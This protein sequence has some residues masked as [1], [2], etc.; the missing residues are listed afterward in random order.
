MDNI[1]RISWSYRNFIYSR[2]FWTQ[3]H[4]RTWSK[5]GFFRYWTYSCFLMLNSTISSIYN[6]VIFTICICYALCR[7]QSENI[8]PFRCSSLYF[9][10]VSSSICL[11]TRSLPH[12]YAC[13][14]SWRMQVRFK[15]P[16][17]TDVYLFQSGFARI[18]ALITPFIAQVISNQSQQ[19]AASVYG[20]VTL[21]AAIACCLLPIETKGRDMAETSGPKK[22]KKR[23]PPAPAP[24]HEF[25]NP[26]NFES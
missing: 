22:K 21:V 16:K 1:G 9:R 11:Y 15:D 17:I 20:V 24:V 10:F 26:I 23:K 14:W 6:S 2:I 5:I 7:G 12:F 13:Y 4:F 19:L 18:G 8:L 25:D 3:N